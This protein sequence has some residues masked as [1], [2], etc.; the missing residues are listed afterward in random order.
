MK[1]TIILVTLNLI[2][3]LSAAAQTTNLSKP[4]S[5]GVLNGKATMLSK[6]EY[7]AAAKAVQAE[8]A[9]SV[10]VLIDENGNVESASAVSGHPLLRVTSERAARDSKFSPTM[11]QGQPVKVSGI[12]V[13]NFVS[14]INW[15]QVGHNLTRAENSDA[16]ITD[17]RAGAILS[18][19]PKEWAMERD[20]AGKLMQPPKADSTAERQQNLTEEKTEKSK[21]KSVT[22]ESLSGIGGSF[23]GIGSPARVMVVSKE[24]ASD[25]K[26]HLQSRLS[27]DELSNWYFSVGTALANSRFSSDSETQSFLLKLKGLEEIA[28]ANSAPV[29]KKTLSKL[30]DLAAK[31]EFSPEDRLQIENLINQILRAN[32]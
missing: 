3:S 24:T 21:A 29:V 16:E 26:T 17:I 28:P 27:G 11:L 5:G 22:G 31:N 30:S 10:Q 13:Y 23:S 4:V 15:L 1:K 2:L 14:G 19:I 32:F 12:I 7:P 6:P 9:V 8:G 25:L 18:Q 20:L